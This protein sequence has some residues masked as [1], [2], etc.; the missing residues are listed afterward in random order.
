VLSSFNGIGRMGDAEGQ[1]ISSTKGRIVGCRKVHLFVDHKNPTWIIET[2]ILWVL[3][4]S[5]IHMAINQWPRLSLT[6]YK[7]LLPRAAFKVDFHHVYIQ[8]CK[9]PQ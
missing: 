4:E 5:N 3:M 2:N 7:Q 8:S 6:F 9:D 1:P